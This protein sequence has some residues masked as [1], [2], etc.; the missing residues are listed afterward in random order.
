MP[1]VSCAAHVDPLQPCCYPLPSVHA[2]A[3]EDVAARC[4]ELLASEFGQAHVRFDAAGPLAQLQRWGLAEQ[5]QQ[6]MVAAVPL[7]QAVEKLR[8]V[9][10]SL[11]AAEGEEGEEA[12]LGGQPPQGGLPELEPSRQPAGASAVPAGAP[13]EAGAMAAQESVAPAARLAPE[14][15][16]E[17]SSSTGSCRAAPEE[18]LEDS[19]IAAP[20]AGQPA[21]APAPLPVASTE[22]PPSSSCRVARSSRGS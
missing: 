6:Q 21:E 2:A 14:T 3:G 16:P 22:P 19:G 9:W 18:E 7:G 11:A 12:G 5:Q 13:S 1:A 8:R 15:A 17:A 4:H 20:R 10:G